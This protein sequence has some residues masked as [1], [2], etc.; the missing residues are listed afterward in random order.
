MI[1]TGNLKCN[2][3]V[4]FAVWERVRRIVLF[5][6]SW[7]DHS[8]TQPTAGDR[9]T[10]SATNVVVDG[11]VITLDNLTKVIITS[12]EILKGNTDA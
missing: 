12:P 4:A 3:I 11:E 2:V 10:T 1:S 9:V 6:T 5:D 7:T 8:N